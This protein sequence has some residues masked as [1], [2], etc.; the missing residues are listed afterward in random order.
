MLNAIEKYNIFR[1]KLTH[2]MRNVWDVK[3]TRQVKSDGSLLGL[4]HFSVGRLALESVVQL[5]SADVPDGQIVDDD[6]GRHLL[7]LQRHHVLLQLVVDEPR[8]GRRRLACNKNRTNCF[9]LANSDD[10]TRA[11]HESVRCSYYFIGGLSARHERV[12]ARAASLFSAQHF[13]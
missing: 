2:L 7:L 13:Y 8:D 10:F 4:H 11:A 9:N 1:R 12:S 5:V 6:P 3:L